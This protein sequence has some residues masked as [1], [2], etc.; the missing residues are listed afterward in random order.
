MSLFLCFRTQ[1]VSPACTLGPS[2]NL[3]YQF[4]TLSSALSLM[5]CFY[6]FCLHILDLKSLLCQCHTYIFLFCLSSYHFFQSYPHSE[7]CVD[8]CLLLA[9]H[10][11]SC[12]DSCHLFDF[13]PFHCCV[14]SYE[15]KQSS[16]TSCVSTAF[17][18]SLIFFD[19]LYSFNTWI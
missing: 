16:S 4:S 1:F 13:N 11:Q 14:S 18:I 15:S 12:Q 5:L 17:Y 8:S 6:K 2:V 10:H 9:F 7:F 3:K 19:F